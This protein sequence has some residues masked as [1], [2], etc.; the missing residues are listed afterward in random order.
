M[1]RRFIFIRRRRPLGMASIEEWRPLPIST[2]KI[3]APSH[4]SSMRE[5]NVS[6]AL[7][8]GREMRM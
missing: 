1:K 5:E 7:F 8:D 3:W 6:G 4:Y 2:D